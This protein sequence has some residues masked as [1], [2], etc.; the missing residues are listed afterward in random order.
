MLTEHAQYECSL[1]MRATASGGISADP[2]YRTVATLIR[3]RHTCRGLLL[4]VGCGSG[5]LFPF[6]RELVDQYCGSDACR[7]DSFLFD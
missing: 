3:K 4:D 7:Y 6:V 2:I 1:Q 5:S